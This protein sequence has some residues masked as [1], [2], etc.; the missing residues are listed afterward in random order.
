MF[1]SLLV[2]NISLLDEA[3]VSVK[4]LLALAHAKCFRGSDSQSL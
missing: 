2:L 1:V 3:P 4:S